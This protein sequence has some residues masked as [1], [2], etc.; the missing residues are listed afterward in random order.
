DGMGL[1]ERT[2]MGAWRWLRPGGW[3]LVEVSPDRTRYLKGVLRR[4]GYEELRSTKGWPEITRVVVA[5]ANQQ[6]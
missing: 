2:A 6:E 1:V 3:L 4:A 5:R